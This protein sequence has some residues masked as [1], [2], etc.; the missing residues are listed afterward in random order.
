MCYSVSV[1]I[2]MGNCY[3]PGSAMLDTAPNCAGGLFVPGTL[4]QAHA[5]AVD[6]KCTVQYWSGCGVSSGDESI[7]FVP[8]GSCSLVAHMGY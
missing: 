6:A 7:S 4:I 5:V 3:G 1:S 2:D 8:P